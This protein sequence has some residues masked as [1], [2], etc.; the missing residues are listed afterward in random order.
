V[1]CGHTSRLQRLLRRQQRGAGGDHVVD[2]QHGERT[3]RLTR[4]ELRSLEPFG[5]TAP[6]LRGAV[7]AVE[8][9]T[10]RHP[11]LASNRTGQQFGLVEPTVRQAGPTGGRPGDHVDRYLGQTEPPHHEAGNVPGDRAPSAVLERQQGAARR[12]VERH[13]GRDA[14]GVEH[15]TRGRQ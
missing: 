13:G 1:H 15:G 12:A 7:G 5:P 8:Q 11:H 14:L 10:A 3:H 9:A 4:T 6:G 2:E